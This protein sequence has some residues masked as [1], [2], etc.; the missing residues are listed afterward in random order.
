MMTMGTKRC[1]ASV[2]A[3]AYPGK[4]LDSEAVLARCDGWQ[5]TVVPAGRL[6]VVRTTPKN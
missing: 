4:P 6:L 1:W 3:A 2:G 5:R